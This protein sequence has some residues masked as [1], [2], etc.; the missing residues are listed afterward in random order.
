[1]T[2]ATSS[3]LILII[4]HAPTG[5][6]LISALRDIL[7]SHF[8]ESILVVDINIHD[9]PETKVLE[10][11][12]QLSDCPAENIL[13]LTDLIGATPYNIARQVM[14]NSVHKRYALVTGISLPMLVK[15]ANYRT[16]SLESW[17]AQVTDSA[18][19]WVIIEFSRKTHP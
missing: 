17:V 14:L 12:Q 1:M 13:I 8:T 5:S 9:T 16:L 2:S 15:A 6:S 3:N 4:T 7:P 10:I 11:Q 18:L 19:E